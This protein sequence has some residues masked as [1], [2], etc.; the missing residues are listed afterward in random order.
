M[1]QGHR[2]AGRE[3]VQMEDLA[4]EPF[5]TTRPGYW[6]RELTDRLFAAA[7]LQPEYVCE[8]DEPGATGY[9]ISAGLGVGLVP[10]YSRSTSAHLPGAWMSLDVPDSH[11]VLTLVRRADTYFSAAAQR[12]TDFAGEYFRSLQ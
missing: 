1:P 4:G 11:R 9:L 8:S 3:R 12:L 2:L 6:P 5:V 10:A 7:G